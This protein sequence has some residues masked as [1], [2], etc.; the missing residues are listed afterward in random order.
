M[1]RERAVRPCPFV[2]SCAGA[3][4]NSSIFEW[5][6]VTTIQ[7]DIM[8][9]FV[10]VQLY[11]LPKHNVLVL[12]QVFVYTSRQ[13]S[14]CDVVSATRVLLSVGDHFVTIEYSR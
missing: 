2:K 6:R 3:L 14:S 11:T 4:L 1:G 8:L 12:V 9:T 13:L 5:I 10:C 7:F